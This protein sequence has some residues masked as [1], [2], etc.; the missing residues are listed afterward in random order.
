MSSSKGIKSDFH[1]YVS[2]CTVC[3]QHKYSALS[4][5][6]LLQ[7]LTIL[8]HVWEDIVM[9]FIEGLPKSR[10]MDT[11]LVV[12]DR[13]S[14]YGYFIELKHP[15][16]AASVASVFIKEVVRL[17]RI[18]HSIVSNRDKV[19]MSHFWKELF[20]LQGIKLTRSTA[21]HPN[22]MDNQRY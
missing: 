7:P 18:P 19:F 11:I 4:P 20:R 9:D 8:S 2:H 15:F 22:P 13:L 3:Q 5:G 16:I 21:Y 12:V 1:Q 14:K 17:H 10:T 6:G